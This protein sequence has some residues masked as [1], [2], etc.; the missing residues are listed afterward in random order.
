MSP[1][2]PLRST[3]MA[4]AHAFL[5]TTTVLTATALLPTRPALAQDAI[6]PGEGYVTRFSGIR[7]SV[8]GPV[9]DTNGTVGSII[10]VRSPRTPPLGQHWVDEPQRKPV[11]A[12]E[13]G[14][15]FGVTLDDANPPNV[16]LSATSAFGLHRAGKDWMAGMWGQGGGPGTIYRLDASTGYAPRVFSQITLNGRP[17]SG[18]ALGNMAYDRANKQLFVSDMETGMIHRIRAADGADLGVYDHGTQGRAGFVNAEN[19]ERTSLPPIAFNTNSRARVEDCGAKFD[20]SPQCWNFAASGRRVWGL[21]VRRDAMTNESRLFYAVWSSPAFAQGAWNQASDDDKRNTVWSVRLDPNGGFDTS[22]VRREFILPDFFERHTDVARAGFS[23]PVSDISFSECGQRPVMLVAERGGIRNLGLGMENSFATPHESRALRY[24]VDDKGTWRPVGRYDVGFYD[25]TKEGAPYMR[26]NCSGGIAFGLG[27]DANTWVADQSKPDQFV[28][29]SGDKLCS[30]EDP[31]NLPSGQQ[32][33]AGS[34][35]PQQAATRTGG[36]GSEV[37]G[38]QGLSEGAFEE[39]V[40]ESAFAPKPTVGGAGGPN[41]AYMIDTDVNV[42]GNGRIIEQELARNDATKIGDVAIYQICEP[43][44]SYAFIPWTPPPVGA[45]HADDVSHA[46]LY[47]HGRAGSHYR[48]GSH[49]PYWSHNRWGS[50]HYFWSHWRY[51]SHTRERS[52]YRHSS[53]HRDRSHYRDG[54]HHR[55]RSHWKDGSHSKERSHWKDGS[56]S[57]ERSHY[58]DGSHSKERSHYKDGSHSKERSHYKDG[59]HDKERSHKKDGSHDKE[60]SHNKEGSHI[61]SLSHVQTGSH[62]KERSHHKDGSHHPLNSHSKD[63]SHTSIE[64]HAKIGS[65]SKERSH[66]KDGSHSKNLSHTPVGSHSNA[67]SH[68]P[69]KSH[70]VRSSHHPIGSHAATSSH[71]RSGS[72]N[73]TLSKG[74]ASLHSNTG[75]HNKNGSQGNTHSSARSHAVKGSSGVKPTGPQGGSQGNIGRIPQLRSLSVPK[76]QSFQGLSGGRIGGQGFGR[77]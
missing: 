37:S 59:S 47:S 17:N 60:R 73:T 42:D 55:E 41:Q 65:H 71:K 70:G 9:I 2:N 24:E 74:P 23:Q 13:V 36:D 26:A 58:K 33:E 35:D 66:N 1:R 67:A 30:R 48:W 72:H 61:K 51:S 64:S 52:H 39:L 6:Q 7:P 68:N 49:D 53:H 45:V 12:G 56:H 4:L 28:W 32:A 50:H 14:Q 31:C 19:G 18:A 15:V 10:D 11:T 22:D 63:G 69:V 44:K 21:G 43:P 5:L 3:G 76:T 34:E 46:R 40:P 54:S 38:I 57:K 20:T 27:Y 75:S 62:S 16:Y 29:T 77:R 25:R 8:G